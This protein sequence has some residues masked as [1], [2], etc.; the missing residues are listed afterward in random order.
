M[1]QS[2][3]LAQLLCKPNLFEESFM[4]LLGLKILSNTPTL[5]LN[6]GYLLCPLQTEDHDQRI[7]TDVSFPVCPD[8]ELVN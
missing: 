2:T 7:N 4:S 8:V 3:T 1:I 5:E 6:I